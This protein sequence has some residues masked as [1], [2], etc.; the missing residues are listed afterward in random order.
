HGGRIIEGH[1]PSRA[2]GGAMIRSGAIVLGL[3]YLAP[4]RALPQAKSDF[5]GTWIIDAARNRTPA[6]AI[7]ARPAFGEQFTATQDAAA[8][9]VRRTVVGNRMLP[10]GPE[11]QPM[12]PEASY[13]VAYPF[14]GS[15]VRYKVPSAEGEPASE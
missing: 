6:G 11:R 15:D 2:G 10:N 13:S 5:S 3:L 9:T 1:S 14:D 4:A 12:R 8:L 7:P